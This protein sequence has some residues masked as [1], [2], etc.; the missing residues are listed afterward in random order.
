MW[1]LNKHLNNIIFKGIS[2]KS[3]W[4]IHKYWT[5]F[6]LW[7]V[8]VMSRW[9]DLSKVGKDGVSHQTSWLKV[10]FWFTVQCGFVRTFWVAADYNFFLP[11]SIKRRGSQFD[12]YLYTFCIYSCIIPQCMVIWNIPFFWKLVFHCCFCIN[13]IKIWWWILRV[14]KVTPQV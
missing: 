6:W 7:I 12:S 14:D 11:I 9:R 2:H 13:F 1:C 10:D 4:F 3:F 8:G 5:N